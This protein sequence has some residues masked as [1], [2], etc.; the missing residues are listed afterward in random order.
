MIKSTKNSLSSFDL[1]LFK[2]TYLIFCK[3]N[4]TFQRIEFYWVLK[5]ID[6]RAKTITWTF[7]N[8]KEKKLKQNTDYTVCVTDCGLHSQK[9]WSQ[10][11]SNCWKIFS[12]IWSIIKIQFLSK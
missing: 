6:L 4:E 9:Y 10:V 12:E 8:I 1:K 11:L 7:T 3:C 5:N 2:A